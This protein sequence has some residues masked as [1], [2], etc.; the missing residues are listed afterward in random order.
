MGRTGGGGILELILHTGPTPYTTTGYPGS[1][2]RFL[3]FLWVGLLFLIMHINLD[4]SVAIPL[5]GCKAERKEAG[6]ISTK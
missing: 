6:F 4:A 1:L 2:E 5:R 3:G